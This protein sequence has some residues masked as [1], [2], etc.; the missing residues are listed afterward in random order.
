[1]TNL[2]PRRRGQPLP[3]V[4]RSA[5]LSE[6][7]QGHPYSAIC[8]RYGVSKNAVSKIALK[9]GLRRNNKPRTLTA[10][11]EAEIA[12]RYQAGE[13]SDAIA[14]SFF[15]SRDLVLTT[16]RRLEVSARPKGAV[17]LPLRHEALD[18]LSPEAAY[19]CG[20][21]FTDG[22]YTRRR[23]T[24]ELAVV[25]QS[26]D[27]GHL[28]KLRDFLGA[29][30]AITPVAPTE[31]APTRVNP[32]G[33]Q[34][35]G[36]YRFAFASQR[37]ADRLDDLGRYGPAVSPELAA[38]RDF[39]RGCIDGDGTISI[40]GSIPCVKLW[41]TPWLLGAFVDFLGPI[42]RRPLSV[43]PT[44]SSHVVSTSYMTAAKIVKRLYE[45]AEV[46][47]DR[48]MAQAERVLCEH[49]LTLDYLTQ[50]SAS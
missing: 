33:G 2:A 4:I 30:N 26:R 20:I 46:A 38:S 40:T 17:P 11:Q 7:R 16:L 27:R 12:A 19:W 22:T 10:G 14:A 6:V 21:F 5:I 48:K 41:G 31:V 9:A 43:R 45:G 29:Q 42:G 18:A 25:L 8:G 37:I 28:I 35:T 24:P 47:L 36:A 39:W 49:R 50:P 34:G 13:K 3:S 44:P 15:I 23:R 1:M 32:Q